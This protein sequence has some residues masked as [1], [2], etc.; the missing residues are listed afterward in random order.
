MIDTKQGKIVIVLSIIISAAV[1]LLCSYVV[2]NT[3]EK[4]I[5]VAKIEALAKYQPYLASSKLQ[6]REF[7]YGALRKLGF[8]D[9]AA[10]LKASSLRPEKLR[11]FSQK[12]LP[13]DTIEKFAA[14]FQV[15]Q[16]AIQLA[17]PSAKFGS[18]TEIRFFHQTDEITAQH[19]AALMEGRSTIRRVESRSESVGTV[20]IWIA[21]E[22]DITQWDTYT[23]DASTSWGNS[24]K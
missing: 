14:Q 5:V 6:D 19:V 23:F 7:A 12:Q 18:T 1:S 21:H 13:P 3:E 17:P 9:L 4:K 2:A 15:P 16:S 24:E 22:Q 8:G 11:I 20:E 10:D